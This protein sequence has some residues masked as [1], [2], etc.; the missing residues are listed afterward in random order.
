MLKLSF[1]K[2]SNGNNRVQNFASAGYGRLSIEPLNAY[3]PC[4]KMQG[5]QEHMSYSLKS[6][7]GSMKGVIKGILGI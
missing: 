3:K 7:Y 1:R 6:I 4:L 2:Q 5:P